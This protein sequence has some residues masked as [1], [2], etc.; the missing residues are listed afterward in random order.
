MVRTRLLG[1]VATIMAIERPH[2]RA[3]EATAVRTS[4][5]VLVAAAVAGIAIA[6]RQARCDRS[7][8]LLERATT[9]PTA[10]VE[11]ASATTL[12]TTCPVPVYTTPEI[13][14]WLAQLGSSDWKVRQ[15]AQESLAEVGQI[16]EPRLRQYLYATDSLEARTR[17]EVALL[18]IAAAKRLGPTI[19]TLRLMNATPQECF[20]ALKHQGHIAIAADRERIWQ[21]ADKPA[22]T[23]ELVEVPFWTA[24]RK[25][26]T[27]FGYRPLYSGGDDEAGRIDITHDVVGEMTSPA[28]FDSSFMILATDVA[29]KVNFSTDAET[30]P[31]GTGNVDLHFTFYADPKWRILEHPEQTRL[32]QVFDE[33]GKKIP[34]PEPMRM[35]AF[36]PESPIWS[37][38]TV[39]KEVPL[40]AVALRIKGSFKITLL[41]LSEPLEFNNLVTAQ[42]V[43]RKTAGQT[44]Q[45]HEVQCG[46]TEIVAR[47][48]LFRDG[49]SVQD[50]RQQREEQS[51]MMF[52]NTGHP[53]QRTEVNATEVGDQVD[54]RITYSV[55]TAPAT[56]GKLV[57]RIPLEQR[58]ITVPFEFKNL[59]IE[60]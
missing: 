11:V 49:L 9:Q 34:S 6:T 21:Q 1:R 13:E 57:I 15:S 38:R 29:R 41:E 10:F 55:P 27:E 24:L 58:D 60:K 45:L 31:P 4:A 53:L 18:Q 39:L 35:Q 36:K 30:N 20:A 42:N 2:T 32:E 25:L 14:S 22:T 26:C 16:A 12:P 3:S 59:P 8:L 56:P 54:Y 5:V 7:S 37:M 19:V 23:V 48:T 44:A 46:P 51:I 43:L 52:D 40:G 50:W 33:R 47:V 17:T 28:S